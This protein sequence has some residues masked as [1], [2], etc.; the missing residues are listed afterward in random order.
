MKLINIVVLFLVFIFLNLSNIFSQENC[1]K[2]AWDAFNSKNY[3]KAIEFSDQ[4]IDEFGRIALRKQ[5]EL[6]SLKIPAPPVGKVSD[7]EKRAIFERGLLNDVATSCWIKGRSYEYL[8]KKGGKNKEHYK[9]MAEDAYRETCK[10]NHGRTWDP[11]GWFWSPCKSA[12][13]RMPLD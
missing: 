11:Q 8:Y 9:K 10:Y 3:L 7:A 2:N 1:L 12:N 4:C 5:K 6:D 13:E